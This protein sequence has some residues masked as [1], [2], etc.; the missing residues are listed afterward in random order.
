MTDTP[1]AAPSPRKPLRILIG[2]DTY[3]PDVNGAAVFAARLAAGLSQRGHT[4][5]I[6]SPAADSTKGRREETHEGAT[7]PVYRVRSYRWYPHDWLRFVWPWSARKHAGEI[8]DDFKP[9]V[10]HA[11]SHIVLGRGLVHAAKARGIR[12]V[13]TNHFMPENLTDHVPFLPAA[14]K[15]F[16]ERVAWQDAGR[17]YALV[18]AVT[19]PSPIA[20][21]FLQ[22]EAAV[23]VVH[24]VSNGIDASLYRPVFEPKTGNRILFVGRVTGEKHL[25]V[26]LR[27]VAT[28]DP[29]LDASLDIVGGGDLLKPLTRMAAELGIADRTTFTGYVTDEQ[30]RDLLSAATV[31]VMPSTAELQSIATLEAMASALPVVGADAMALPHLI[32]A[33][34]NGYLFTPGDVADLAQKLTTVLTLPQ[35]RL[36]RMKKRSLAYVAAHDM[37]H[38]L[39]TFESLYRGE[40]VTDLVT[41]ASLDEPVS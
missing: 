34:D 8:L 22:R 18:A 39:S 20:A 14:A 26:L 28:L 10:V 17:T 4:V 30:K 35:E 9:D 29:A 2:V 40:A 36:T 24:A 31:F 32:H 41:D 13:A 1:D 33:D 11:Q 19:C 21:G 6:A 37:Q 25:D 38:T 23:P 3:P 15:R 27:A 16:A 12:V 7:L 5:A